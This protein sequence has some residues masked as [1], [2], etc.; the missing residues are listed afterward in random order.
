MMEAMAARML[1]PPMLGYILDCWFSAIS[2]SLLMRTEFIEVG[3]SLICSM[4]YP[5]PVYGSA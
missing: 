4:D 3:V 1:D 5:G 2:S